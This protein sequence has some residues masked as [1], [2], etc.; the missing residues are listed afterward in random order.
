MP[1]MVCVCD[2]NPWGRVR[3]EGGGL[4]YKFNPYFELVDIILENRTSSSSRLDLKIN[5]QKA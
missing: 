5:F 2:K 1:K 4:L 3:K